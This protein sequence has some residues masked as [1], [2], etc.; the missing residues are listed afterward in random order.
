M[1]LELTI[2][3]E[4]IKLEALEDVNYAPLHLERMLHHGCGGFVDYL[5][6]T[7]PWAVLRC[8]HCAFRVLL[9]D[10]VRTVQDLETWAREHIT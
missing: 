9:P 3:G 4:S 2:R 5:R 6:V 1:T 10:T 7:P 8:R